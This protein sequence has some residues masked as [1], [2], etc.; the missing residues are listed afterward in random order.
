MPAHPPP[1]TT[2]WY[3]KVYVICGKPNC[4]CT[5]PDSKGHGPYWYAYWHE[6]DARTKTSRTKSRYI[7]KKLKRIEANHPH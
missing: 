5:R 3:G 7:G 1:G 2:V 4:H 6:W